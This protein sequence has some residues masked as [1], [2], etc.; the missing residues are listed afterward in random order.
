MR[1]TLNGGRVTLKL[2][3]HS[4]W[5]EGHSKVK[6]KVTLNKS[7]GHSKMDGGHSKWMEGHSKKTRRDTLK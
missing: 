5:T 4:K 1:V 2:E 6:L 7:E 3:G